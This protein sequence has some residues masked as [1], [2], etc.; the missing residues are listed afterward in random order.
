MGKRHKRQAKTLENLYS[1]F[2]NRLLFGDRTGL[3]LQEFTFEEYSSLCKKIKNYRAFGD[4][5][6][7]KVEFIAKESL[8]RSI[9][10]I[11]YKNQ[12][13]YVVF[14]T[15]LKGLVTILKEDWVENLYGLNSKDEITDLSTG[16]ILWL[17]V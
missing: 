6:N 1:H 3:D 2:R 12:D 16:E 9:Y 8:T 5:Y 11:N 4:T 15:Q 14:N 17:K 13:M 7:G 10:R